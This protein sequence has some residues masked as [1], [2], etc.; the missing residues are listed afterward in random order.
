VAWDATM[1]LDFT[2][3]QLVDEGDMDAIVN[4]INYLRYATVLQ[5]GVRRITTVGG[6]TTTEVAV[7][8][9]PSVAFET[10]TIYEIKGFVKWLTTVALDAIVI[11]VRE[12]AGI[13]GASIQSFASPAAQLTA[14]GY[15]TP[16]NVYIKVTSAVTRPY[17][18]SVQ[19]LAGS[20]TITVDTTSQMVILRSG[21]SALMTDV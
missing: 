18:A 2:D 17:T 12:G 8:Q 7:M 16:F 9:T 13:G 19:R 6:I 4:N 1:P 20:G 21:D 5:G 14:T 11:R 10:G 3:G 15:M